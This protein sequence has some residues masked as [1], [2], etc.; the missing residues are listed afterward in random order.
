MKKILKKLITALLITQRTCWY[1]TSTR[2]TLKYGWIT[3]ALYVLLGV[4]ENLLQVT[5]PVD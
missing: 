2:F 5:L 1:D 4:S 3:L